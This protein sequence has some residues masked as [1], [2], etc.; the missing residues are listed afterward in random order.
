MKTL[1]ALLL[2]LV[3]W[4]VPTDTQALVDPGLENG[5]LQW[6]GSNKTPVIKLYPI[7][8]LSLQNLTA[9]TEAARGWNDTGY[10]RYVVSPVIP[11]AAF[12]GCTKCIPVRPVTTG[13]PFTAISNDHGYIDGAA[14]YLLEGQSDIYTNYTATHELGHVLGLGHSNQSISIMGP[15]IYAP[16]CPGPPDI[17]AVSTR[18]A[19]LAG[20]FTVPAGFIYPTGSGC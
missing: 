13:A 5:G 20:N 16:A 14:V 7:A 10:V 12:T 9:L 6:R 8:P 11:E 17:E 18:Y 2:A 4:L 1:A 19:H 15:T 3:M